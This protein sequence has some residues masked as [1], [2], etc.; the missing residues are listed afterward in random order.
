[1]SRCYEHGNEPSELIK[2]EFLDQISDCQLPN[3]DCSL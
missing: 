3:D 2:R 1:V